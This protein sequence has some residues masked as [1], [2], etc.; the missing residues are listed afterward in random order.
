MP[1]RLPPAIIG[2]TPT[3]FHPSNPGGPGIRSREHPPTRIPPRRR[4]GNRL[5]GKFNGRV[6]EMDERPR[7]ADRDRRFPRESLV[8]VKSVPATQHEPGQSRLTL[9]QPRL[10]IGLSRGINNQSDRPA[11]CRG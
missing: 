8:P 4:G 2:S 10:Q 9:P 11:R 7:I 3:V 5:V 6:P 1:F